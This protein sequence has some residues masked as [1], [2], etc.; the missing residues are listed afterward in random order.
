MSKNSEDGI[1]MLD[2]WAK[3]FDKRFEIVNLLYALS[4]LKSKCRTA[5]A[6]DARNLFGCKIN[7]FWRGWGGGRD[8]LEERERGD[9]KTFM[10]DDRK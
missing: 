2:R 4:M 3:I 6:R 1:N 9:Q 5:R 10:E 8:Y 7:D